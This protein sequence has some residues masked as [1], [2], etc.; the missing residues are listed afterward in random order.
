MRHRP[1][2]MLDLETAGQGS[3]AAIVSIGACTVDIDPQKQSFKFYHV[4]DL[5]SSVD[6]GGVIDPSTFKWWCSQNESARNIFKEEGSHIAHA[7]DEFALFVKRVSDSEQENPLVWGCGS[8]FDNVILASAYRR[9]GIDLPWMWWDNRCYRTM[10]NQFKNCV[11]EP[12]RRG[13]KHNA[14]DDAIHQASHLT[15]ILRY[16]NKE[17]T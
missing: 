10:K 7:L 14:L 2:I 17:S 15:L 8:D 3:D 5:Q 12:V 9:C 11:A 16:I 4:V 13:I 1:M 6:T